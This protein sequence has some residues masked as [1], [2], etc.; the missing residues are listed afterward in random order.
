MA[1]THIMMM[2]KIALDT[3]TRLFVVL[4]DGVYKGSV[5]LGSGFKVFDGASWKE[6]VTNLAEDLEFLDPTLRSIR[7]IARMLS[8]LKLEGSYSGPDFTK[9]FIETPNKLVS[10]FS[11]FSFDSIGAETIAK[12]D[13]LFQGLN[14]RGA[15]FEAMN[16][17]NV[18]K[19][20]ESF[21]SDEPAIIQRPTYIPAIR[22]PIESKSFVLLSRFGPEA[23][24]FWNEKGSEITVA[25]ASSGSGKRKRDDEE[26][27]G[28]MPK[29]F[30]IIPKPLHIAHRDFHKVLQKG[31]VKMDLK[32]RARGFR[33]IGLIK[34]TAIKPIW[35]ALVEGL[36][37]HSGDEVVVAKKRKVDAPL[38]D[39]D[40]VLAK[41]L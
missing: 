27:Y 4:E 24:S 28:Y 16:P 30:H 34:E 29:E 20:V 11:G 23:P 13:S 7:E 38:P 19:F 35:K 25:A 18:L 9:D 41:F 8:N 2:V 36:E 10:V 1:L 3:Q 14:L 21:F 22:A 40:D 17:Q 26:L 12:L 15:G 32:E 5:I 6:P 39:Y 31:A 33:T 37:N